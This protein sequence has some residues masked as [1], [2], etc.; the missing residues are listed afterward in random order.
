MPPLPPVLTPNPKM[1]RSETKRLGI[2]LESE[3]SNW[4]RPVASISSCEIVVTEKGVVDRL[5]R[6]YPEKE[7]YLISDNMMQNG[8]NI[9]RNSIWKY[10]SILGIGMVVALVIAL[11]ITYRKPRKYSENV[12]TISAVKT[13][14]DTLKEAEKQVQ[15]Q[16]KNGEV[17]EQQYNALKREIEEEV[18]YKCEVI[19]PLGQVDDYYNLIYRHNHNYFYL[20]K[21][22]E[23]VDQKLE[24]DEKI[25]IEKIIWVPIDEAITLY[26]NMQNVL[27]GKIV[28]Q[29]ELP[30]LKLAKIALQSKSK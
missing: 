20:V 17:S 18:G 14:L 26:E 29:R 4:V 27:V 22:G 12:S 15:A 8:I 19:C 7:F 24:P 10:T 30:I 13:K 25:R 16:F 5:R 11:F 3:E 6:D 23:K 2:R 28:K 21:R 1:L 9:A